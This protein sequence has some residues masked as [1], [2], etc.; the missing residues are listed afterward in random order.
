[1]H[2][3]IRSRKVFCFVSNKYFRNV[4]TLGED[5]RNL[6]ETATLAGAVI[7]S[8]KSFRKR[9]VAD[10]ETYQISKERA[11]Q[12]FR[13]QAAASSPTAFS[14]CLP[15]P[16]VMELVQQGLM[17]LA[18]AA[19]T[20]VAEEMMAL[21]GGRTGRARRIKRTKVARRCAGA[22]SAGIAWWAGK[23]C[24]CSGRAC[25]TYANARSPLRQLRM[26]QRASLMEDAVWQ[27]MMHGLTTRRYSAVVEELEQAYGV[28]KST[29][30]EH[31]ILASRQ[32]LDK[33]ASAAACRACVMRHDDRRHVL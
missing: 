24:R 15:L 3:E 27:K 9:R 21:G 19:F 30:S 5:A 4:S 18:L 2:S 13:T 6:V 12:K 7:G 26:L 16:E 25:A 33:L 14:S 22:S 10:E 17:N 29:I 28:E 8:G 31:F 20:K 23:K 32:R 11:V 1:M